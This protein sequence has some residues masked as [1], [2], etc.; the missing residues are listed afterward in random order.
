MNKLNI[1]MECI[2]KHDIKNY[3]DILNIDNI[4]SGW[5]LPKE[6]TVNPSD[7]TLALAKLAKDNG[8]KIFEETEVIS[9]L[10]INKHQ[11]CIK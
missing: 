4:Y 9:I 1:E 8:V 11:I 10:P 3:T 2:S 6:A 7:V 5:F